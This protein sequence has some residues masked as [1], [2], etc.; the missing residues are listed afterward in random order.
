[1]ETA[2]TRAVWWLHRRMDLDLPRS[3]AAI[4]KRL[5][6]S[7]RTVL[8]YESGAPPAWYELALIG[9]AIADDKSV[10][11]PNYPSDHGAMVLYPIYGRQEART[12]SPRTP[13][14]LSNAR[15][16]GIRP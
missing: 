7:E 5:G 1:M 2:Y 12:E 4:A 10:H 15:A 14:S 3:R 9:S 13:T 16:H 8:R 11:L 6:I